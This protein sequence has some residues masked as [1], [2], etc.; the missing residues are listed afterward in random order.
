[1]HRLLDRMPELRQGG[2]WCEP[3]AGAGDLMTATETYEPKEGVPF[4]HPTWTAVELREEARSTLLGFPASICKRVV[5][6]QDFFEWQTKAQ[7]DVIL[8]N[9]PFRIA[10]E[11]IEKAIS[12]KPRFVIMLLRLNY[13]GSQK[14]HEFF[15]KN[16]AHRLYVIPDR[17]AF[18]KNAKGKWST[19]SIEYAWFVWDLMKPPTFTAK[20]EMLDLTPKADRKPG[21]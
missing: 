6:P 12:L 11:F 9:P 8:S 2:N 7:F 4:D 3:A 5:C 18:T 16:M 14:R 1:M 20:L 13:V 17:P 19:D 15:R 10:Q 21:E